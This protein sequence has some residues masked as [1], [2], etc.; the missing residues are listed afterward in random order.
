MN[1]I[2]LNGLKKILRNFIPNRLLQIRRN[3]ILNKE[4]LR[5]SN[6]STQEI[7]ENIYLEGKWGGAGI[8]DGSG[9][10]SDTQSSESYVN[11]VNQFLLDHPDISKIV[12]VGCGD[13]RVARRFQIS[14][15]RSYLGVDIVSQVVA[16]NQDLFSS[17]RISFMQLNA[18]EDNLPKADLFLVRQVLQHLS[19]AQVS[20]ILKKVTKAKYVLISEHLPDP[21]LLR[22]RNIDKPAGPDVRVFYGSGIYLDA[23][24]FSVVDAK[25][26]FEAVPGKFL[27]SN[28]ERIVT[29]LVERRSE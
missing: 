12:D 23:P 9:S 11:F 5:F 28:G 21:S 20:Q 25:V 26:V 4:R 7:F 6:F 1:H 3:R 15:G 29:Y 16:R 18:V 24:P 13:F 19:N 22:E 27:V 17:D 14:E 10:G 8:E 2:R